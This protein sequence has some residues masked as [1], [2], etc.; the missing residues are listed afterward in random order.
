MISAR[1]LA[2]PIPQTEVS[3]RRLTDNS[4]ADLDESGEICARGPCTMLEY[5]DNPAATLETIDSEGWLHT[6]DLG[7]MDARGYL[8]ITGRVQ[9]NDHSWRRKPLPR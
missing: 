6:G 7:T 1:R 4:C 2:S 9:R 3:I 8:K 5:H